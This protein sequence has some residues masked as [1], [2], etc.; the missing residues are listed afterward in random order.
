MMVPKE[1]FRIMAVL[2]TA[3]LALLITDVARES[4]PEGMCRTEPIRR[5]LHRLQTILFTAEDQFEALHGQNECEQLLLMQSVVGHLKD[6]LLPHLAAEEAV[7]YPAAERQVPGPAASLTTVL[8]REHAIMRRWIQEMEELATR[9]MPDTD[10]FI[11]RGERLL[12][13][14]ESHFELDEGLLFPILD[15]ASPPPEV[16]SP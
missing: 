7:L 14:I 2:T 1:H 10:A 12:G 5:N 13:L 4:F 16:A 8:V 6:Y 11:R 3:F 15:E 9:S